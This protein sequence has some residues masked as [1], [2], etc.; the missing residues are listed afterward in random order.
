MDYISYRRAA[1]D[2]QSL[3]F[4]VILMIEVLGCNCLIQLPPGQTDC[5]ILHLQLHREEKRGE[6][7]RAEERREE[8][9]QK[10]EEER[11]ST[12]GALLILVWGKNSEK[13][14]S[15]SVIDAP[16]VASCLPATKYEQNIPGVSPK[17]NTLQTIILD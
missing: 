14:L 1:L 7:R 12:H 17:K 13:R 11:G 2:L 5:K 3:M 15:S 10:R 6:E 16:S 8:G 4:A 9:E